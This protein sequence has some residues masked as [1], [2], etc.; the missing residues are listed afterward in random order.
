[1]KQALIQLTEADL[2]RKTDNQLLLLARHEAERAFAYAQSRDLSAAEAR[3]SSAR[4]LLA[5]AQST[6]EESAELAARL[7]AVRA[8]LGRSGGSLAA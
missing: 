1:M 8:A 7:E 4:L 2:R 3:Y 5:A 6:P